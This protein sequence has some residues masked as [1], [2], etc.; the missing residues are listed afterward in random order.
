MASRYHRGQ[1][2]AQGRP[3]IVAGD[4]GSFSPW[5]RRFVVMVNRPLHRIDDVDHRMR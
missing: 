5:W 3:V 2:I 1:K 4:T